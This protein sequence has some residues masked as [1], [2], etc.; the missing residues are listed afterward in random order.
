MSFIMEKGLR[1]PLEKISQ[2]ILNF[3]FNENKMTIGQLA[4]HCTAWA[5]YFLAPD[6]AKP[7][8]VGTGKERWTCKPMS[9]PLTLEM[10]NQEIEKGFEVIRNTLIHSDDDI[11]EVRDGNKKGHGYIIYRLLI[12]VLTHSN[13]M[14]YLRQIKDP[15]WGFGSHFGDMATVI[16]KTKYAT[17]RDLTIPG[18]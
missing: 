14:A 16:I 1:A 8:L 18:F 7:W 11:L 15:E 3:S 5:Q 4:I 17:S 12:H 13:Q 9:Y 2:D 6:N 10:V